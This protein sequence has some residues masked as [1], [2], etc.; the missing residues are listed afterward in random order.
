VGFVATGFSRSRD[1]LKPVTTNMVTTNMVTTNIKGG[2]DVA[3]S[4]KAR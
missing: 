2:D 1:R 3:E 4:S